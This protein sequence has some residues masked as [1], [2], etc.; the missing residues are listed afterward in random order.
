MVG[1]VNRRARCKRNMK[2][3][4][5]GG[6]WG[7]DS[8]AAAGAS[9]LH[10]M[11]NPLVHS[12]IGNC[13]GGDD[14]MRPG[15]LVGGV[16]PTGLP[17]MNPTFAN[18]FLYARQFGGKGSGSSKRRGSQKKNKKSKKST[19]KYRQHGGRYGFTG[20]DPSIVNGTPWGATY[21]VVS[22]I[23]CEGTRSM[24]PPSGAADTLN[25]Q[26]GYLWSGK[27]GSQQAMTPSSLELVA[28]TA[29]YTQL[30][31]AG[32]VLHSSAGTNIMINKP[33]GSNEM[34][35]ACLKTGGGSRRKNRKSRKNKKSS[36]KSTRKCYRH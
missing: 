16:S 27:G 18:Q 31:N 32:D 5:L 36:R 3:G 7:F 35:A 15:Y 23:P 9:T 12:S 19:R 13:R 28:P 2:G 11:N 17:G 33:M 34:N 30:E 1:G 6:G 24:N 29:R 22:H 8:S 21:P 25:V 14:V 20:P 26:G 10:T 4:G